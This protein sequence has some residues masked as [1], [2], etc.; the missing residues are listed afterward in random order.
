MTDERPEDGIVSA[1]YRELASETTPA[2]LDDAVLRMAANR[3]QHPRYSRSLTWTR[4][5]AWAATIALCLAITLEVTREPSHDAIVSESR[6]QESLPEVSAPEISSSAEP[7][8]DSRGRTAASADI[9]ATPAAV[10]SMPATKTEAAKMAEPATD[11]RHES[12]SRES[13]PGKNDVPVLDKRA[14]PAAMRMRESDEMQLRD[15]RF[16]AG[17]AA[18]TALQSQCPATVKTKPETWLLCIQELEKAGNTEA[19]LLEK[20][21]LIEVFPDFRMP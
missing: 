9:A 3:M 1:R 21:S 11:E 4:P 7:A 18:T 6:L 13:E 5:L 16:S 10:P 19:A 2:H 17:A 14:Y 8:L 20:E 12:E 15:E